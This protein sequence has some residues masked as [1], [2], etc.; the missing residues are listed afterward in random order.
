MGSRR[1]GHA[2]GNEALLVDIQNELT[3][4]KLTPEA[5]VGAPTGVVHDVNGKAKFTID[6]TGGALDK[7]VLAGDHP[8][9]RV[10]MTC[11]SKG[12]HGVGYNYLKSR[13]SHPERRSS[14]SY[15]S[16]SSSPRSSGVRLSTWA[17]RCTAT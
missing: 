6:H 16:S 4:V 12:D 3:G 11:A 17:F 1:H 10:C 15:S 5:L 13:S 7:I 9:Q 8:F 14:G 2:V